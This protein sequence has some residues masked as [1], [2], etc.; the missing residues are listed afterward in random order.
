MSPGVTGTFLAHM[1][2]L[3]V[4][5]HVPTSAPV[6]FAENTAAF[7]H[8][9]SW[10][11]TDINKSAMFM[12]HALTPSLCLPLCHTPIGA[13]RQD[14]DSAIFQPGAHCISPAGWAAAGAFDDDFAEDMD[15]V[16][17]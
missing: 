6:T 3:Y 17:F 12:L 16:A 15:C 5:D 10:L 7:V 8:L 9:G 4:I 2:D 11:A 13:G 1:L 14:E